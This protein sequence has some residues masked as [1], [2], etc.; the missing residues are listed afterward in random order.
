[1]SRQPQWD[2]GSDPYA[3]LAASV[4]TQ[5]IHDW[6]NYGDYPKPSN[7]YRALLKVMASNGYYDVRTEIHTFIHSTWCETICDVAGVD[8]GYFK[9][10]TPFLPW[11]S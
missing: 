7:Q 10:A 11:I 5:A 6:R 2:H 4:L 9:R 1:M 3:F 8:Y